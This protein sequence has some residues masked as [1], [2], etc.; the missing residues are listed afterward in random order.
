VGFCRFLSDVLKVALR[1]QSSP[2]GLFE[3]E[4]IAKTVKLLMS[5]EEGKE[6][7]LNMRKLKKSMELAVEDGGSSNRALCAFQEKI[8][9]LSA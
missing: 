2:D 6:T 1:I 5:S 7:K 3:K 9:S 4:E 8:L